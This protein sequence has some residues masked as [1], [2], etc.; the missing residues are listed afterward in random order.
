MRPFDCDRCG[1]PTWHERVES[2]AFDGPAWRCRECLI[3]T[4]HRPETLA[5]FAG[6]SR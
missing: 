5:A 4:E 1:E 2:A 6:E 3:V